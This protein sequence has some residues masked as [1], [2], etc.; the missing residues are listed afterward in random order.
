MSINNIPPQQAYEW[1]Q[2]GSAILIDVRQPDEFK[3]SHI[4]YALSLPLSDCD[5]LKAL[6]IPTD[7]KIIFQCQKGK[8]GEQACMIADRHNLTNPVFNIE[9]GIEA[10][11]RAKLPIIGGNAQHGLSIFR[12]VQLI[13][14]ALITLFVIL[15]FTGLSWAFALAG[16]F[17]GALAFAGFTGWC[18]LALLLNKM[19]WNR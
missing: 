6:N 14:G 19:P 15:G 17:G 11:Q 3:T 13:V 9:G 18:G 5:G 8:R 7:R 2:D 1:L 4:A 10:W 16:L 12:Q